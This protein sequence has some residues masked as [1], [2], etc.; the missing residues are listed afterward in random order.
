MQQRKK[1]SFMTQKKVWQVLLDR[2]EH[3]AA[4][5]QCTQ[6]LSTRTFVKR[7]FET[8][9]KEILCGTRVLLPGIGTLEIREI[10]A[11]EMEDTHFHARRKNMKTLILKPKRA[12]IKK[13]NGLK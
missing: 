4:C 9:T 12:L 8:L 6:S 5:S 10:P 11:R 7:L 3:K 1:K 13:L 2:K